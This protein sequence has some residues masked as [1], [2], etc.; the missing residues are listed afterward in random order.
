MGIREDQNEN[1]SEIG[2]GVTELSPSIFD[3]RY[4]SH[5]WGARR[6]SPPMHFLIGVW[7]VD[8][9]ISVGAATV[10]WFIIFVGLLAIGTGAGA[11]S[12]YESGYTAPIIANNIIGICV[13]LLVGWRFLRPA[14]RATRLRLLL[15]RHTEKQ[16][17][18]A[19]AEHKRRHGE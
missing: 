10:V 4:D 14:I 16:F 9:I 19:Y 18:R 12:E 13:G 7:M 8:G 3:G 1:R 17:E 11:I 2:P 6:G 15:K 5:W